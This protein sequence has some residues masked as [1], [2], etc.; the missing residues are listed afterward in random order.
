MPQKRTKSC[1]IAT[2]DEVIELKALFESDEEEGEFY[3]FNSSMNMSLTF[4]F[5]DVSDGEEFFGF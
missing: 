5:Q 4:I 2:K 1:P 3:G